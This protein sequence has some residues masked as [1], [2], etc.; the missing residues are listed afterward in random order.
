MERPLTGR[1]HFC[2]RVNGGARCNADNVLHGVPFP[3]TGIQNGPHAVQMHG[4]RHHGFIDKF[5]PNPF[6]VLQTNFF[7]VLILLAE[8]SA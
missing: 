7:F 8:T 2:F 1:V 6:T 4:M 5:E 3:G